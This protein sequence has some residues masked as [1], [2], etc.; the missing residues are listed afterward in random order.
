MNGACQFLHFLLHLVGQPLVFRIVTLR[1]IPWMLNK[2][3]VVFRGGYTFHQCH[4]N[5]QHLTHVLPPSSA[6]E[7]L[8][9]RIQVLQNQYE[10]DLHDMAV[11][12]QGEGAHFYRPREQVLVGI[13]DHVVQE[14]SAA[15]A[16][17]F[18]LH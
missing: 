7:F 5:A 14:G 10:I 3:D 18:E 11:D 16:A 4:R 17:A 6:G 1:Q 8:Q 2:V 15:F 12:L 13:I 9:V